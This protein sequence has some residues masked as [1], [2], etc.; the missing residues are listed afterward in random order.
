MAGHSIDL[1]GS[2]TEL[3]LALADVHTELSVGTRVELGVRSRDRLDP[4]RV[5]DLVIGAGFAPRAVAESSDPDG[6]L[7][8]AMRLRTLADTVG[9]GMRVL[10]CGLNPSPFA[11]D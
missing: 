7:V 1:E 11:A 4:D 10:V 8:G 3:P 2:A 5:V 9:E 6:W